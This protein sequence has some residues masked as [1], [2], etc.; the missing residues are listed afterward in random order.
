[1]KPLRRAWLAF[2]LGVSCVGG[3]AGTSAISGEAA[4]PE[5]AAVL[6]VVQNFFD[7]MAAGD[8][9]ALRATTV[10]TF[11]FHAVRQDAKGTAV[12]RRTLD[13]FVARIGEGRDRVL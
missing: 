7:A 2:V 13:E 8:G 12:T 9:D 11:Q 1:M 5:K 4:A 6:G 10:P 3:R